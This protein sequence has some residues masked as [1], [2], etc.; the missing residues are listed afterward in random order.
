MHDVFRE[1]YDVSDF[2]LRET[3]DVFQVKDF[4]L[5]EKYHT[6]YCMRHYCDIVP[7]SKIDLFSLRQLFFLQE[8]YHVNALRSNSK[9]LID[10]FIFNLNSYFLSV[11]CSPVSFINLTFNFGTINPASIIKQR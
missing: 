11:S 5:R 3:D 10:V 8:S 4:F 9:C 1:K 7:T 2:F 6:V